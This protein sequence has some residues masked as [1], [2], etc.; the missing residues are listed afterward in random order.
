MKKI[1]LKYKKVKKHNRFKV[2][3][4]IEESKLDAIIYNV[5]SHLNSISIRSYSL[6]GDYPFK[7][8]VTK[9]E[10]YLIKKEVEK[11]NKPIIFNDKFK[12]LIND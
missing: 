12:E 9:E 3:L 11:Y 8:S 5:L 4:T 2:K 10:F 1:K 7:S 6:A